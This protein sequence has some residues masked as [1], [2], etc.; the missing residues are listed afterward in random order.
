MRSEK[1]VVQKVKEKNKNIN[2]F[3]RNNVKT[4]AIL[5]LGIVSVSVI[6]I[7]IIVTNNSFEVREYQPKWKQ[8]LY[9]KANDFG[10]WIEENIDFKSYDWNSKGN[11]NQNAISNGYFAENG[12]WEVFHEGGTVYRQKASDEGDKVKRKL[13]DATAHSINVTKDGIYYVEED[14]LKFTTIDG[15]ETKE[16]V[17]E[18]VD[19]VQVHDQEI[20]YTDMEDD[21]RLYKVSK[22]GKDKKLVLDMSVMNYTI[23]GDNIYFSNFEDGVTLYKASL[24]GKKVEKLTERMAWRALVTEDW[25]YFEEGEGHHG[26]LYRIPKKGGEEEL[27]IDAGVQ[28]Y[29]VVGSNIY[30]ST[31]WEDQENLGLF[32]YSLK[33]KETR[34]IDD[35]SYHSISLINDKTLNM[36][37]GNSNTNRILDLDTQKFIK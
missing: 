24:D 20:Y 26:P 10:M 15:K 28:S 36:V 18:Y 30:Y 5:F 12:K 1:I 23:D 6:S 22:D 35:D 4:I 31:S 32:V 34:K 37:H 17:D 19:F 14:R 33:T 3:F 25:I 27:L 16:L 9:K 13:V 7:S 8:M 11:T 21:Q 2:L 29:A